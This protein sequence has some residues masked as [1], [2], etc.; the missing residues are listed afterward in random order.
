MVS[1]CF[2]GVRACAASWRPNPKRPETISD[3]RPSDL[4]WQDA[5]CQARLAGSDRLPP[6]LKV[7]MVAGRSLREEYG[8]L[9]DGKATNLRFEF[10]GQIDARLEE[11]DLIATPTTPTKAFRLLG[12]PV[13]LREV[14]ESRA[15]SMALNTY[16]T[17]VSGHPSFCVPCGRGK[18]GLP[19]G[20]QLTGRRFDESTLFR[21]EERVERG[22]EGAGG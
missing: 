1:A 22:R 13:G 7:L 11:V 4:G 9:Y 21:A 5:F 17:N 6:G 2:T 3:K 16:P 15:T 19:I 8:S 12:G 10:R 18:N 20:L 14:V